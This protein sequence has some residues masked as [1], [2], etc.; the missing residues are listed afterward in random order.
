M[1]LARPEAEALRL[2]IVCLTDSA[3]GTWARDDALLLLQLAMDAVSRVLHGPEALDPR[4]A[5]SLEALL[6]EACDA[7]VQA[8]EPTPGARTWRPP[9]DD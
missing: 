6:E 7:F 4:D 8:T 2:A 3:P 9:R 5:A 1:S